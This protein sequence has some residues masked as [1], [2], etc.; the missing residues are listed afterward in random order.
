MKVVFSLKD[1]VAIATG[2]SQGI[3]RAIALAFT[4]NGC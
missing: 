1:K 2:G 4:E 3:G